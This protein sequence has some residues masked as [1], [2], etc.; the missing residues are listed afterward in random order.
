M[1][2]FWLGQIDELWVWGRYEFLN[3]SLNLG[4]QN[5]EQNLILSAVLQPNDNLI[6]TSPRTLTSRKAKYFGR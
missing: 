5:P 6:S 4:E 3:Y 2:R 1:G